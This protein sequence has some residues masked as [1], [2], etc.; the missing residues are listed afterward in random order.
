MDI[1]FAQL[2]DCA[3]V[4]REGKLNLLG[5]FDTIYSPKFPTVH[6]QMQLVI[7]FELHRVELGRSHKVEIHLVDEDGKK[8]FGIDGSITMQNP[9]PKAPVLHSD[10]IITINNLVIPRPGRYEF[11]ILI[12]GN[13]VKGKEISLHVME[14]SQAPN[15]PKPEG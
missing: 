13:H 9:N 14:M 1:T 4:S 5:L 3:N 2:A 7:R 8:L 6:P 12:D 15:I 10:Q 11:L